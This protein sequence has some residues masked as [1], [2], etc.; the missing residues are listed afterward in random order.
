[1]DL[2]HIVVMENTLHS[3]L[4]ENYYPVEIVGV[5]FGNKELKVSDFSVKQYL[6][7]G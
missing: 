2:V 3:L 1:M 6:I 4:N 7:A 5:Q